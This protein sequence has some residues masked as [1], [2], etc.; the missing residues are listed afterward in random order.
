MKFFRFK[1]MRVPCRKRLR[2]VCVGRGGR[3]AVSCVEDG[4]QWSLAW[5]AT[6]RNAGITLGNSSRIEL[7]LRA[8]G[9]LAAMEHKQ[10]CGPSDV[11]RRCSSCIHQRPCRQREIDGIT[12]KR[13]IRPGN[14]DRPMPCPCSFEANLAGQ[15][16]PH[17]GRIQDALIDASAGRF[18][19]QSAQG[20]DAAFGFHA[21]RC[22]REIKRE[23]T[24]AGA[25]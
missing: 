11:A 12:M 25:R 22:P 24:P 4:V 3:P 17:H 19:F 6:R 13:A 18:V 1:S 16:E 15:A 8:E 9:P 10:P 21:R 7:L 23:R 5:K 14:V 2:R 20:A